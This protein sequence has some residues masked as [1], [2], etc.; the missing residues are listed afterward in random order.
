MK[1]TICET[2]APIVSMTD[3][4]ITFSIPSISSLIA[5]IFFSIPSTAFDI[6]FSS[7]IMISCSGLN[8]KQ[9]NQHAQ[10]FINS[11][12]AQAIKRTLGQCLYAK[13]IHTNFM[14]VLIKVHNYTFL[15]R[16]RTLL[17]CFIPSSPTVFEPS[18]SVLPV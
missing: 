7:L 16:S 11:W 14:R 12:Q 8:C 1:H 15:P 9:E 4:G 5:S 6:P 13:R 10:E 2:Q 3:V 18:W 17:P